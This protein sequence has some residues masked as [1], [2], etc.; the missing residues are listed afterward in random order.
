MTGKLITYLGYG[1]AG[2]VLVAA[3]LNSRK[4]SHLQALLQEAANR[5]Q[6]GKDAYKKL[7]AENKSLMDQESMRRQTIATLEKS[8]EEARS[9][10]AMS[11]RELE[12]IC[13]RH[14]EDLKKIQLQKDHLF[15][16]RHV[17]LEQLK[18][19]DLVKNNALK[20]LRSHVLEQEMKSKANLTQQKEQLQEAQRRAG[21]LEVE[22]RRLKTEYAKVNPQESARNRSKAREMERLFQSMKGLRELAEERNHNLEVAVRQLAAY[23]TCKP[24]L[25]ADGSQTPLGPLVGEALEKIGVQLMD[26]AFVMGDNDSDLLKK[27]AQASS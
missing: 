12:D 3:Y 14:A 27:G 26:D 13:Q 20:D 6:L 21:A 5:F 15:E 23:V 4:V 1:I 16:E 19:S 24:V 22:L 7:A 25:G 9:R 8:L 17:L 11:K 10:L 18:E 2:L